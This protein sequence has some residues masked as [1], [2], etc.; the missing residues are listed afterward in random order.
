V[1]ARAHGPDGDGEDEGDLLVGQLFEFA[2][3][4]DLFEEEWEFVEALADGGDGFGAGQVLGGVQV[5]GGGIEGLGVGVGGV[6]GDETV[7]ALE[8]TPELA[9]GDAAEPGGEICAPGVVS[10]SVSKEGEEDLLGDLFS[11]GGVAA[12]AEGEAVDERGMTLVEKGDGVGGALLRSEEKLGIG[13]LFDAG[14]A[15]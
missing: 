15:P 11:D 4:D 7:G 6:D 3:D 14:L 9:A 10:V 2:E 5:G 12:E 13:A 1:E 8:V